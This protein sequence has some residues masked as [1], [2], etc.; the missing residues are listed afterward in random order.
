LL[1]IGL[2]FVHDFAV[3]ECR[4]AARMREARKR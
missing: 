1:V 2:P 3:A 4:A